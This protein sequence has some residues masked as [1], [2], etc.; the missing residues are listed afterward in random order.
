MQIIASP[1]NDWD[2]LL[3]FDVKHLNQW[4]DVTYSSNTF[5]VCIFSF[6]IH[7]LELIGLQETSGFELLGADTTAIGEVSGSGRS[8]KGSTCRNPMQELRRPM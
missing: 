2:F 1:R 3:L 7:I 5:N 4:Y 6:I 8:Q